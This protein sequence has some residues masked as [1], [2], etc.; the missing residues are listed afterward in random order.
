M[1]RLGRPPKEDAMRKQYKFR[2]DDAFANK[3][4]SLSKRTKKPKSE[5]IREGIDILTKLNS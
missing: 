1:A 5:L 4:D 2:M 3:L